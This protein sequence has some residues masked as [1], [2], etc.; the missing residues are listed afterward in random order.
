MGTI[1]FCF[2]LANQCF[3]TTQPALNSGDKLVEW[4]FNGRQRMHYESLVI[5]QFPTCVRLEMIE[6]P[7][8]LFRANFD[9]T[10]VTIPELPGPPGGC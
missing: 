3:W 9:T 8:V 1:V 7:D 5:T 6:Q 4:N 10:T 2:L